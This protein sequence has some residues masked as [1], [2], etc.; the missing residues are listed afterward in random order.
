ML[1]VTQKLTDVLMEYR[2]R[3]VSGVCFELLLLLLLFLTVSIL[4][5]ILKPNTKD[6]PSNLI[7]R[8]EY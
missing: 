4:E 5:I 3:S 8:A 1:K 7:W 6:Q 2:L